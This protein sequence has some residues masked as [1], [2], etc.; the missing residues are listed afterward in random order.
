MI[1]ETNRQQSSG[2]K[3]LKIDVDE[4]LLFADEQTN[5]VFNTP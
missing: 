5:E 2:K 3:L 1:K 4:E